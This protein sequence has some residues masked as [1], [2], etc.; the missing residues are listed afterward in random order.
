MRVASAALLCNCCNL[1][2]LSI[3][4]KP[5]IATATT[6]E[7]TTFRPYCISLRVSPVCHCHMDTASHLTATVSHLAQTL[8]IAIIDQVISLAATVERIEQHLAFKPLKA[9]AAK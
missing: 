2:I 6:P 7:D 1:A 4:N 8:S 9:R 3:S 5:F